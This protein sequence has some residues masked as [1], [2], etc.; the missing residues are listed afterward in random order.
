[1][2]SVEAAPQFRQARSVHNLS[3]E[4]APSSSAWLPR[5]WQHPLRAELP[6][7]QHLRPIRCTDVDL[8][9]QAVLGSQE[10]LWSMYGSAWGWPSETLSVQQDRA[11][12]ARCERQMQRQQSF[13][14]ALFDLGETE[15][16]GSVHVHPS[17]EAEVSA[18]ISW[19]VVDWLVDGP[20][21]AALD[22][23]VPQWIARQWPIAR[24]RF[25]QRELAADSSRPTVAAMCDSCAWS[26]TAA[27][28]TVE[29]STG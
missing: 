1:M 27:G 22:R 12:L 15:L 10:R 13:R 29:G 2:L 11:D 4:P 16:L 18:D 3:V 20:I 14:Y 25:L 7:G 6:T 19:W 26:A 17:E 8:D 9:L 21:E 23:F 28:S 24:P 5:D